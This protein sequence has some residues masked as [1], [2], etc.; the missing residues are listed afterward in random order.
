MV[1]KE[2]EPEF[3]LFFFIATPENLRNDRTPAQL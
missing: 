3:S 1:K 2:R